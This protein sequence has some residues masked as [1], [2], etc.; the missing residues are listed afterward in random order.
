M[1][2]IESLHA[3]LAQ[4]RGRLDGDPYANPIALLALDLEQKLGS[5]ALDEHAAEALIQRLTREAFAERA[6]A[7]RRYLGELDP[8][9]NRDS[10]RRL[11]LGLARDGRRCAAAVRGVRR[12]CRARLLRLR[13]HGAP[14]FRPDHGAADHA[15]RGRVRRRTTIRRASR[16]WT[17]PSA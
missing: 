11:L 15:G 10:I 1:P 9:R 4:A 6:A 12:R 16:S 3:A 14:D 7:A 17:V 8:A 13:V 5:G 2:M